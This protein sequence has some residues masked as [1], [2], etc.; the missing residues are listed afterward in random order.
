MTHRLREA[1]ADLKPSGPL[2]GS[3][4]ILEADTTRIGGKES[5]KH[6][7]KRDS[8]KIGGMGKQNCRYAG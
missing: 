7:N 8:K 6:R 4:K 3:G 5:N 2:D 1:M